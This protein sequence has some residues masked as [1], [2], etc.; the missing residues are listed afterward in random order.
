M[1]VY[2]LGIYEEKRDG[3]R[4]G[5]NEHPVMVPLWYL[6]VESKVLVWEQRATTELVVRMSG[7]MVPEANNK[8]IKF[9]E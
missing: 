9:S 7:K 6:M 2:V 5:K 4:R 3:P 8:I 1:T